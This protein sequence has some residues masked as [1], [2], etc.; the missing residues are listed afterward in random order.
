MKKK[1]NPR[2][3]ILC[4]CG[5]M[6]HLPERQKN[7][8]N[9]SGLKPMLVSLSANCAWI[10]FSSIVNMLSQAWATASV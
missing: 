10:Q 3:Q 8:I 5:Y 1:I 7:G 6:N 9:A 2:R 4:G